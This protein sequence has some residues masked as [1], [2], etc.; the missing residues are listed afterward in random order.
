MCIR[1]PSISYDISLCPQMILAHNGD[2]F[3]P[4]VSGPG[5]FRHNVAFLTLAAL[6]SRRCWDYNR[7]Q[8]CTFLP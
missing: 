4:L 6:F 1:Y 5:E 3:L 7:S 8:K 2:F